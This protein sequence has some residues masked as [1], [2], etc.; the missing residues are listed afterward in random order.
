MSFLY[1]KIYPLFGSADVLPHSSG[2][3]SIYSEAK[4]SVKLPGYNRVFVFKKLDRDKSGAFT[5][6]GASPHELFRNLYR[7][8]WS[9]LFLVKKIKLFEQSEF[10]IF[11]GKVSGLKASG[12]YPARSP[13]REFL[14]ILSLRSK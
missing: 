9:F 2:N 1:A 7:A 5:F 14:C 12:S 3:A 4:A 8:E 10:L 6:M 13:F 11:R